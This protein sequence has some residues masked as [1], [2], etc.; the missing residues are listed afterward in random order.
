MQGHMEEALNPNSGL[1]RSTASVDGYS[2]QPPLWKIPLPPEQNSTLKQQQY[3]TLSIEETNRYLTVPP[4]QQQTSLALFPV[5]LIPP[6]SQESPL[7]VSSYS[8]GN[9]EMQE[10]GRFELG[11][12]LVVKGSGEDFS[13]AMALCGKKRGAN[14]SGDEGFEKGASDFQIFWGYVPVQV[15]GS[16]SDC[17]GVLLA[18]GLDKNG[19]DDDVGFFRMGK[20]EACGGKKDEGSSTC[21]LKIQV[22][23]DTA[24]IDVSKITGI[25]DDGEKGPDDRKKKEMGRR[26]R[27][28]ARHGKGK[29]LVGKGN[30]DN[31]INVVGRKKDFKVV[32]TKEE[33][34]ELRFVNVR[35]QRKMW[36]E[37][38]NGLAS[39]LRKEYDELVNSRYQKQ[40][41]NLGFDPCQAVGRRND[42]PGV[43]EAMD[44]MG[45]VCDDNGGEEDGTYVVDGCS[46]TDDDYECIKRPA[47]FVDGEPNF[48]SG[49]PEDGLEYL[50]RVRWEA[51]QIPNVKVAKLDDKLKKEQTIYMP[52]IPEIV[53]CE[54]HLVPSMQWEDEFLAD[55]SE[56]RLGLSLLESPCSEVVVVHDDGPPPTLSTVLGMDFAARVKM[57]TRRMNGLLEQ[58]SGGVSKD[59]CVW[60]FA[61]CATVDVP[62]DADACAALRS[63]L[64]KCAQLLASKSQLD[65]EAVM[66]N[67]LATIAGKYFRQSES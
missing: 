51:S 67:I 63:L 15:S 64:R 8:L 57:L 50:R 17:R 6:P 60:L 1:E 34:E 41:G 25:T 58:A 40:H 32:Y 33:M 43:L 26:A 61:L 38:Y 36:H 39:F 54:A 22:I 31:L 56:L 47:F 37:I 28:R 65:D 53:K 18:G 46:E 44:S 27:I 62:L 24:L 12:H 2:N 23:D 48:D 10:A 49:P 59:D 42:I 3:G 20:D 5:E 30:F 13:A 52:Q 11:T 16:S 29:A 19:D 14:S 9:Q 7:L 45:N 21:S 55:F 66:L 35:G 4:T